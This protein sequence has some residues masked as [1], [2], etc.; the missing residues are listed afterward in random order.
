MFLCHY[1]IHRILSGLL[2]TF[3][4]SVFSLPQASGE[5]QKEGDFQASF[6]YFLSFLEKE[7]RLYIYK[8]KFKKEKK[9]FI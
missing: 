5:T 4:I 9:D 7:E 3:V 6:I 8:K 2:K 1:N